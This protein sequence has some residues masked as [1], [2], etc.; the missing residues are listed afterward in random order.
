MRGTVAKALRQSALK[1]TPG[2]LTDPRY[3]VVQKFDLR[4]HDW[5]S[6]FIVNSEGT[7]RRTYLALKKH[8]KRLRRDGVQ[9]H[10]HRKEI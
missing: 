4:T 5:R 8:Y 7:P 9:L 1:E 2:S 3:Q 6:V 10:V